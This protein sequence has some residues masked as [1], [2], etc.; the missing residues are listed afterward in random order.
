MIKLREST[1]TARKAHRCDWCYGTIQPG[2]KYRRSTNIYDD[3]LYDWVACVACDDLAAL[4]WEWA[5]RPDEGIGEDSFE[6]WAREHQGDPQ[7]GFPA[8]AYLIRRGLP[9]TRVLP[10]AEGR[11]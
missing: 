6:E 11:S 1:P 3:H 5:G 9:I 7:Q 2:E 10:P 8:C 4:V